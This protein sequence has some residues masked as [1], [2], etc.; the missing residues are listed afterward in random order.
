MTSGV[1]QLETQPAIA[2]QA[3]LCWLRPLGSARLFSVIAVFVR[4]LTFAWRARICKLGVQRKL[5]ADKDDEAF[6]RSFLSRQTRG[7]RHVAR[8]V[9]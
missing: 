6:D 5:V 9:G 2:Q 1:L 8:Y 3:R 4:L 7:A